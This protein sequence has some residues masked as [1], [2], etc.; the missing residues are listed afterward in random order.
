MAYVALY[1]SYR[2]TSFKEVIGQKHVVQTLKNAIIENK[3]SHAYIFSGLRGIGKTTI[4]RILAKA[5]NCENPID[6]EPCNSC[7]NCLS[8]INDETTDIVELDAASNNGVDEMRDILEKVNFLPSVLRK[9]VYIIDE[10]HMLSTAAFNALLKTLEEPPAYVIF[11]LATTEPHKI[12]A[13]ILSRCQRFDF[14]QFT[15]NELKEELSFV[16]QKENIN[17]TDE[18]IYAIAEASDGGMRDAL[19]I[20]DQANVY[21]TNEIT[22]EDVDSVTGRIS[23]YKLIELLNALKNRDSSKSIY[24]INELV[25]MGK[26]TNRLVSGIIQFC[27][28][29]LLYKSGIESSLKYIYNNEEF[30]DLANNLSTNELFYYIDILV[31]VQNKIRFTNSQKIYLEVGIIKIVNTIDENLDILEKIHKLEQNVGTNNNGTAVYNNEYDNRINALDNK[32]KRI[33]NEIERARI[34]EFKEKI[35]AK[36]DLLEDVSSKNAAIPTDL[37]FRLDSLEDKIRVLNSTNNLDNN[38]EITKI[39]EKFSLLEEQIKNIGSPLG[40][41]ENSQS[42]VSDFETLKSQLTLLE[43]KVQNLTVNTPVNSNNELAEKIQFIEEYISTF[44]PNY[45]NNSMN[46]QNNEELLKEI[47]E[48]KENYFVLIKTIQENN[49]NKNTNNIADEL[50]FLDEIEEKPNNNVNVMVDELL[51]NVNRISLKLQENNSSIEKINQEIVNLSNKDTELSNL[52]NNTLNDIN[53]IKENDSKELFEEKFNKVNDKFNTVD[54]R[55]NEL[56]KNDSLIKEELSKLKQ[57]STINKPVQKPVEPIKEVVKE[58]VKEVVK[59]EYVK[60]VEEK[61]VIVPNENNTLYTHKNVY[62]VRIVERILHEARDIECREEKIR[63]ANGWKKLED[64]VGYVLAPIAKMLLDSK[65]VANG[66]NELLI[67]YPTATLCNHIMEPKNYNDAKQVLRITFGKDYDFLALPERTWQE[68]R[69][70]YVGQ[71]GVGI[72]YPKLTPINN[73]ELNVVTVNYKQTE[74][75]Q[76]KPLQQAKAFF[77]SAVVEEEKDE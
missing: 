52:I 2:P 75:Y 71:Y 15:L 8:I 25:N 69:G 20:L 54:N 7:K 4:A 1:R 72:K 10:A 39:N 50:G 29:I 48:L 61:R 6:G 43:E 55:L 38:E 24:I 31:D 53:E 66:K 76:K 57:V 34:D 27:R 51:A 9:K 45:D 32:I 65:L 68:K 16:C 60:P 21:A 36:L 67:V 23:N 13:T 3:T 77:G 19:S 62:D 59:E 17:I 35:E 18:A 58:T 26:E 33:N 63:L 56:D 47:N 64:K 41:V 28:D 37:N 46:N 74:N 14:K 40:A 49:T 12:P 42:E 30:K 22:V 5:V 73:K 11:V 44:P 70:E